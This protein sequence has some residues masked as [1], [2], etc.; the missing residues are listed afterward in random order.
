M[1]ARNKLMRF[2][3]LTEMRSLSVCC[4]VT[5]TTAMTSLGRRSQFELI[6]K[7]AQ[8]TESEWPDATI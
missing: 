3:K 8:V 1:N 5:A 7:G 4:P 2:F 6:L